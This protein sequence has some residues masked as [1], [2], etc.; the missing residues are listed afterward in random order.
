MPADCEPDMTSWS[1]FWAGPGP[2][3]A[4]VEKTILE[5]A[6]TS[7]CRLRRCSTGRYAVLTIWNCEAKEYSGTS[8]NKS[9]VKVF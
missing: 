1:V 7:V 5:G 2:A 9:F 3:A 4:A 6:A 8:R